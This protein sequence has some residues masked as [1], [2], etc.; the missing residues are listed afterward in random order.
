MLRFFGYLH[1]VCEMREPT[2]K[3]VFCDHGVGAVVEKY[4]QWLEAKQL[5][6]SSVA[7]Y[8]A[9]LVSAATFATVEMENPPPLDQLANLR[10]Q[11]EK[12]A[13]EET[14]YRKKAANWIDW[15]DVQKTRVTVIKAYNDASREQ[16]AGILKDLVIIL[17]HS[18]TPPGERR[19]P[20]TG[21][22]WL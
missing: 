10:R 11:A 21:H 18:V 8:L 7:N 14:L 17:L 19:I 9:A 20:L 22:G 2:M 15:P 13:R 5:K 6:W 1:A 16:K 4:A 12:M 3:R